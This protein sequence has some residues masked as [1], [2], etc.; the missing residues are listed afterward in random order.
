VGLQADC[1]E[2]VSEAVVI[3]MAL[4]ACVGFTGSVVVARGVHAA[5]VAV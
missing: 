3:V 2:S 1:A 4:L 5:K